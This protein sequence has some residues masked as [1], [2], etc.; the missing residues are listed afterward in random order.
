MNLSLR[1]AQKYFF[2]RKKKSFINFI[3]IISMLGLTLGTMALVLILSVFNGL[4]DLNRQIFKAFDPDIKISPAKG[5][6]IEKSSFPFAKLAE[7]K[8][9]AYRSEVLQEKVLA[10]AQNTQVIGLAR[11]VD[12][13]FQKNKD[14]AK[15]LIKGKM[16][17]YDADRPKAFVGSGIFYL[18]NL[19][20][21]DYLNP[22]VLLYPKNQDLNV[23]N[24]ED[25]ISSL[26]LE[27]S[28]A[29]SLEQQYDNYI[30][31][32]IETLE[33]LCGISN[34][35]SFIELSI[36]KG[37]DI[38]GLKSKL[39]TVLGVNYIVKD[40]DEQNEVL[41]KAIKIEKLF[42]FIGMLFIMAIAAFNIFYGLSMLVLDKKDDIFTLSSMGA[43]KAQIRNIFVFEGLI[44]GAIGVFLGVFL[45]LLL[46][47]L[48]QRFALVSLGVDY[49][50]VEA[51]PVRIKFLDVFLSALAVFVISGLATLIPAKKALTYRFIR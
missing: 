2:S 3:S 37:T 50:M 51:Y 32:P 19:D 17:V 41:F 47:Y 39:K 38:D 42:I 36:K 35:R 43:T 21:E 48:Q 22:L 46:C 13:H 18:L 34:K 23:L 5:K 16:Q 1:I 14:L 25:N 44:I 26:G 33:E 4:E 8:E 6:Y 12:L 15:S 24:P 49:A 29:F 20:I 30:Y 40:R 9:I 31:L 45:G 11:G 28:G 10:R 27:V 7:I